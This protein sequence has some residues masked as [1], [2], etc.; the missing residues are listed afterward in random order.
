MDY[1][2]INKG[3]QPGEEDVLDYLRMVQRQGGGHGYGSITVTIKAGKIV[4]VRE[5]KIH[6]VGS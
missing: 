1:P 3:L 6:Q 5:E 4:T 2:T